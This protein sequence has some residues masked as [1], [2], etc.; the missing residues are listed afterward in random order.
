MHIAVLSKKCKEQLI[1]KVW[2]VN[3]PSEIIVQIIIA[4]QEKVTI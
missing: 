4:L 2:N 3:Q 1:R